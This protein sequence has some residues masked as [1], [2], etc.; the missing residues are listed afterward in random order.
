M[1]VAWAMA[2]RDQCAQARVPFLF[3]QWGEW[4]PGEHDGRF[5]AFAVSAN[6][7]LYRVGKKR[8]GR[9]LDGRTWDEYPSGMILGEKAV[10]A[11]GNL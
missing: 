7:T 3:K 8:A 6:A 1:D 10:D 11:P 5:S 4:A 2:L 9:E